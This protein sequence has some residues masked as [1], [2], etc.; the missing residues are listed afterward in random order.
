ME[1]ILFLWAIR[2]PAAGYV[3]GIN[4]LVT[5]F[6]F[7]FLQN[8]ILKKEGKDVDIYSYDVTGLDEEAMRDVEADSFWCLSKILQN[9]QENYIFAQP[10]IQK[11]IF[12]LEELVQ[13][14][15]TRLYSHL[16]SEGL[17]FIQFAFR[18]MNCYLMRELPLRIIIRIFDTYLSEDNG[19]KRFHV[20]FCASFLVHFSAKLCDL[21]FQDMVLFIQHLPTDRWGE[22]EI[23]ALL[24][25]SFVY[26]SL[27]DDSPSHLR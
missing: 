27:F 13:R 19:F 1:R 8:Q 22:Q 20:Y 5:P 9:I 6:F 17:S 25:Q 3:Q 4:D 21:D 14:I 18:W 12:R 24:S 2:N 16:K 7:V 23:S 10:G 26:Q 11:M 15:D